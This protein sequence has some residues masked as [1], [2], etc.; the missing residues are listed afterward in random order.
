MIMTVVAVL[1]CLPLASLA[2]H[3][4]T[5][6][7][8]GGSVWLG[9]PVYGPT[10]YGP[11]WGPRYYWAPPPVYYA[12][13]EPTVYVGRGEAE[14]DYWYYCEDPRG[15]YPY[16]RSCPGGWMKVVPETVPPGR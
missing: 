16:V 1:L 11:W 14:G 5:R 6:V 3:G 9:P 15:Y 10:Y 7:Y 2:G 4:K 8:V 13:Q 12:P